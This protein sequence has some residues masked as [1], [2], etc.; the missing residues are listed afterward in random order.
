[1]SAQYSRRGTS[2]ISNM[3]KILEKI[4]YRRLYEYLM[5]NNLL[6]QHNSGFKK[7]DSTIN[8]LLKIIH[9]IYQ[10]VNDGNDTCLVFL[11]VS[12]AFDKVWHEGLLFKINQMGI[13]GSL[14]DWLQS[15]ISERHQKVV[16]NG[17]ESNGMVLFRGPPRIDIRTAVFLIFV[18]DIVDEM[19]CIVN[20]FADDTSVQQKIIDIT[21]FDAVNRDLLRLS[22]ASV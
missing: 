12:K 7:N 2:Q 15:Y 6:T 13:T 5:D 20:L 4:V 21:S 1:M 16:L 14:L 22:F 10:D 11:D 18:Y 3:S 9:Q 17:M 8:Q 19:E